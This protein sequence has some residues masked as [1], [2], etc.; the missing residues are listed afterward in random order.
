MIVDEEDI[1]QIK[2]L[3]NLDYKVV[4]GDSLLGVERDIFNDE[5]FRKLEELKPK[6]FNE[7]NPA[8]KEEIKKEI[9]KLIFEI[10]KGHKVFDFEVYFSEVFHQKD[11]FDVVIANPP[12]IDSETMTNRGLSK[13][14]E[15]IAKNYNLVRG[16]WDIYIAFFEKGLKLLNHSGTLTY[17]TPDKWLTKPFG[18]ELRIKKLPYLF[19]IVKCGRNIFETSLVDSVITFF[20]SQQTDFVKVFEFI[21]GKIKHRIDFPKRLLESASYNLDI[22]FSQNIHLLIK[23]AKQPNKVINL[24]RCENACATSDAYKLKS[25]LLDLKNQD[26]D[27]EK[28]FKVVNTGTIGKYLSKWGYRE[29]TYI[30]SKYLKPA[31]KKDDFFKNFNQTYIKRAQSKKLIVKGITLLQACIDLEG[32]VIPGKSTLVV[33]S[34]KKEN[35]LLV[36]GF[37]NSKIAEFYLKEKFSSYSYNQGVVFTREMINNLPLPSLT[38]EKKEEIISLVSQILSLTQSGDYLENPQ[39]QAQVK[40]YERQIDQLVYKLYNLTEEEIRIIEEEI[41]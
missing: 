32:E 9:D 16:N 41:K 35:L 22:I 31:V 23:I 29:M 37:L 1:Y 17:I 5:A 19:T 11:G 12:Y 24:C 28:Y 21:S 15:Y 7:T 39:K 8:K 34:D 27:K 6:Y 40:E 18:K 20:I 13:E 4:C 3:P 2:P 10:T 25:L 36:L 26:F 38:E 14:R 30:K 33:L